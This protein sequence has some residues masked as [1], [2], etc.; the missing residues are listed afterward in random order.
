MKQ[1]HISESLSL[2]IDAAT[3]TF[4]F[5]ARKG[6]GKTYAAGKLAEL[7]LDALVQVVIIDTVGNWYGLRISADGKGKGFDIP[8]FGGLR[9][10]IPLQATAGQ[11]V[12]DVAV[13]TGRSMIIDVSQFSLND[14]KRFATAF[15]EQLW[16]R[17]KG[18][19]HPTPLMLMIEESQ[20]I[21]PQFTK[22]DDARMVGIY[23]EIIRLGRNYG[24]GCTMISQ[25]PQS[26]NKE[27][28]NQ[29]ECLFVL[30]VNGAQERKALKEWIVHQGMDVK[31]LDELPSLPVGTA[32]CWS[33]QWLGILK[34]V[35]I[36]SKTTFDASATPKVGDKTVRRTPAPL[37]LK[38]I[39]TQM[40]ATIELAKANDP[41]LLKRRIAEQSREIEQ[42]KKRPAAAP[43]LKP[44]KVPALTDHERTRLTRLIESYEGLE[45]SCNRV[46]ALAKEIQTAAFSNRAEI[47][48]FKLLL[49]EKLTTLARPQRAALV[50]PAN[51]LVPAPRSAP[52]PHRTAPASYENG[53]LTGGAKQILIAAVQNPD[54]VTDQ[55]LAVLTGYKKTSRTTFKQKLFAAGYLDKGG[56]GYVA[57]ESGIAALGNDFEPLPVGSELREHWLR[58]LTGGELECFK[59]YVNHYPH[60]V[61]TEDLMQQT[62]YLKTSVTTFRQKL[63]ARNLIEGK[64]A[65]ANLFD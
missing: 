8:V 45:G 34:K 25:R 14:R 11:L 27:V 18:E 46:E 32:Y 3:Q 29:T 9:G 7:L 38:E 17:K 10:D 52:V 24:I 63:S 1:L 65:S 57:T 58:T 50:R 37:D 12:A 40:A 60:E 2:P 55:Q 59:V 48:F 51:V 42:L 4:A 44:E 26:V 54:G 30:Q 20:L 56:R 6:A 28:L 22:G 53:D 64:T 41:A 61:S 35:A 16:K 15:G 5:I 23:E 19:E 21:I 47:T 31:L 62:G 33:P 13:D 39:E 43:A 36:S 49:S